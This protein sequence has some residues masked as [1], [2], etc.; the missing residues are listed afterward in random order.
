MAVGVGKIFPI[1]G[2]GG[3]EWPPPMRILRGWPMG[4][5]ARPEG[6][7]IAQCGA[8]IRVNPMGQSASV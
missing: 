4:R 2:G 8:N 3:G 1:G 6:E 5:R 7:R